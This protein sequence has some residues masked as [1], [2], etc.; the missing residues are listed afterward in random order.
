MGALGFIVGSLWGLRFARS[1]GVPGDV[2]VDMVF[3][4]ALAGMIG[5]RALYL[6]QTPGS[7]HGIGSL[8][9]PRGGGSVF[10][11]GPLAG[12]P[13]A[14]WIVW[15]AKAP[16][17]V[18]LDAFGLSAPLAHALA[19]LGCL[20]AGCCWGAPTDLPWAV[21]YED[22]LAPGPHGVGLHPVQAYEA[23]G[24][25]VIAGWA[26]WR[27]PR[28]AWDGELFA[29]WVGAYAALRFCTET[30]RGDAARGVYGPL[31]TSQWISLAAGVAL[32]VGLAARRR[33]SRPPGPPPGPPG[34]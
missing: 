29:G 11:G 22:P 34:A 23:F 9:H 18:M 3:W 1:R 27:A 16:M 21:T 31:S 12:L 28:R 33:L 7:W 10:Y 8:L 2:V 14:A 25:A 30:L 4:S 6:L 17:G 13:V 19:R 15:R 20:A 5:S 32:A 24:L 26:A